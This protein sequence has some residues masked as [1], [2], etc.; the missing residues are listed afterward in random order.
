MFIYTHTYTYIKLHT[1]Q[2]DIEN[3][4]YLYY[5]TNC[6][7]KNDSPGPETLNIGGLFFGP[8][9]FYGED[10][11]AFTCIT[12]NGWW[13]PSQQKWRFCIVKNI[14]KTQLK[15]AL[16]YFLNTSQPNQSHH[17][18]VASEYENPQLFDA[19]Y[20]N[21]LDPL[22]PIFHTSR[23]SFSFP[24]FASIIDLTKM[25]AEKLTKAVATQ[26]EKLIHHPKN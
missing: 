3:I 24:A 18:S 25:L 7:R 21:Q 20:S 22:H 19:F 10:I 11:F 12:K 8:Q 2:K 1:T 14:W 13:I 26:L 9:G 23:S 17:F 5:C 6:K 16:Q 15:M 4:V